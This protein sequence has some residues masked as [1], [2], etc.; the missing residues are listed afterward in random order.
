M[1]YDDTLP[2]DQNWVRHLIRDTAASPVFSDNEI[3][4]WLAEARINDARG[5]KK[6]YVAAQIVELQLLTYLKAGEGASQEKVD[7]LMVKW[8]SDSA[9]IEKLMITQ[10]KAW[11]RRAARLSRRKGRFVTI[12]HAIVE[13]VETGVIEDRLE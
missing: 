6:Y 5:A 8:G 3:D 10:S 4:A 2:D 13:G 9:A 7:E 11:M 1:A 12:R